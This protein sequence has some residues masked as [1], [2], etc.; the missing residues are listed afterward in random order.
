[1]VPEFKRLL[2]L[3]IITHR[4]LT[5]RIITKA[6]IHHRTVLATL[7][8]HHRRTQQEEQHHHPLT[9]PTVTDILSRI[10]TNRVGINLIRNRV[11]TPSNRVA[12]LSNQDM[13]EE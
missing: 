13:E 3:K 5:T 6:E 9:R 10:I 8:D 12:I 4:L 11:G 1:M 7:M 2:R